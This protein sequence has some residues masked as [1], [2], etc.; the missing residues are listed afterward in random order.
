MGILYLL[1]LSIY[2]KIEFGS[3]NCVC[4]S[5]QRFSIKLNTCLSSAHILKHNMKIDR[6]A[7]QWNDHPDDHLE[8]HLRPHY[9]THWHLASQGRCDAIDWGPS[10]HPMIALQGEA[11]ATGWWSY[12]SG[13][14][15][16]VPKR[17]T[18]ATCRLLWV[19]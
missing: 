4:I 12:Q 13:C 2:M 5:C 10:H 18:Q 9:D 11:Q 6:M 3:G 14:S 8:D 15:T 7:E 1:L 17:E 16:I 19:S